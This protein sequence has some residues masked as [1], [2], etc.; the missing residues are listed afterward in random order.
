MD[1]TIGN[2]V[3]HHPHKVHPESIKNI[4]LQGWSMKTRGRKAA[5]KNLVKL[6]RTATKYGVS[7]TQRDLTEDTKGSLPVWH[8]IGA[9]ENEK[10]GN[11]TVWADCQRGNHRIA[12]T[13]DMLDYTNTPW[14]AEHE[15]LSSCECS[16]C[17]AARLIG[18]L[19][20]HKCR[21]AGKR[22][23]GSLKGEWLPRPSEDNCEHYAR[24]RGEFPRHSQ[25]TGRLDEAFRVFCDPDRED[26]T[27]APAP[28]M[29]TPGNTQ[30]ENLDIELE[31]FI[32]GTVKHRDQQSQVA[33]AGV[34]YGEG[35]PRNTT[36][37]C[38][39]EEKT[40]QCAELTGSMHVLLTTPKEQDVRLYFP[41]TS[42]P[43]LFLRRLQARRDQGWLLNKNRELITALIKEMESR[44]GK[45][46]MEP[47]ISES[48]HPNISE[49]RAL[50]AKEMTAEE[51]ENIQTVTLPAQ[52]ATGAKLMTMTQSA[53]Y[54]GIR[55]KKGQAKARRST[56]I[57]LDIT[58]H[59]LYEING[60]YPSDET[61]W[62]STKNKVHSHRH[63]AFLWRILHNSYKI[64]HYWENIP[65]ME[66]R[67]LCRECEAPETM[68]HILTSCQ[69]SGQD[70]VWR[71]AER[72]WNLRAPPDWHKP[73]IGTIMGSSLARLKDQ[74]GRALEGASRLYSIIVSES[75]QLIWRNRC[76]WR[77]THASD[78]NKREQPTALTTA[79]N[80]QLNRRL[81]LEAL[82]TNTF[83][84]GR[85][86]LS[87][88]LVDKTWRSVLHNPEHVQ[89][90]WMKT[91]G[92]L[93]GI[94]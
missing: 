47:E 75:A 7:L 5:P 50:A 41:N 65:T 49:A 9:K 29:H 48:E 82:Q 59:A 23:L 67:G 51:I 44:P 42:V 20:P 2:Y 40:N 72:V 33:L 10:S 43:N 83:R 88:A 6:L 54:H 36:L 3:S 85:K 28:E 37:K 53:F 60:E 34:Y 94:G 46:T 31:T 73:T 70:T 39:T 93:V 80:R 91:K 16:L 15:L 32:C 55:T 30:N 64:G 86:A 35:D 11:N 68:E 19:N 13:Q 89:D 58:R 79:W 77:I 1:K 12:T 74:N 78:P 66:H 24:N 22:L 27:N 18:C 25:Q 61:I 62:K 38:T 81:H 90:D 84:Y 92:D 17:T 26:P 4:F 56:T 76:K 57:N 14:P 45:V 52:P 69:V 63:R 71:E 21:E 87:A 8:H